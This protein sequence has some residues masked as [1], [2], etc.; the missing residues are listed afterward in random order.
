MN[1]VPFFSDLSGQFQGG[2]DLRSQVNSG[3][4]GV[5]FSS[6][7]RWGSDGTTPCRGSDT[8]GLV[9]HGGETVS[10]IGV[11]CVEGVGARRWWN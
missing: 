2:R 1:I 6:R 7:L 10:F 5:T 11:S 8:T 9:S 4:L 3:C